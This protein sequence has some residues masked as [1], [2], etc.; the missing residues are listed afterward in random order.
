MFP[1]LSYH[2]DN[3]SIQA[4][5]LY[6]ACSHLL[7]A[8]HTHVERLGK[9]LSGTKAC[10]PSFCDTMNHTSFETTQETNMSLMF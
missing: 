5:L 1:Q 6:A 8:Q 3:Q 2:Q 4:F 9:P 10:K 7:I